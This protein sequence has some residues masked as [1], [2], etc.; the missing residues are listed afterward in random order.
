MEREG[1]M[2]HGETLSF[3]VV[4]LFLDLENCLG[5]WRRLSQR[6]ESRQRA[7]LQQADQVLGCQSPPLPALASAVTLSCARSAAP[8]REPVKIET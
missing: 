6:S 7:G 8:E 2:G 5:C 3:V 4:D 1:E